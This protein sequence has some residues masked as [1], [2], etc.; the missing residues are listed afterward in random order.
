MAT[1]YDS[2]NQNYRS[3]LVYSRCIQSGYAVEVV[4]QAAASESRRLEEAAMFLRRTIIAAEREAY[5]MSWPPPPGNELK[6]WN[7]P[8]TQVLQFLSTLLSG[9][10][11]RRGLSIGRDI[12]YAV[13][14]GRWMTP[15]HIMLGMSVWH[16]T[17]RLDII[18]ILN[19]FGHCSRLL[20]ILTAI[21]M[22]VTDHDSPIPPGIKAQ[23]NE[24][25]H[26]CWDNFDLNEETHL[27]RVQHTQPMVL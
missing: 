9:N 11:T 10:Q 5:D 16:L 15:K 13:T 1:G 21:H 2:G 24:V 20:E 23:C 22:S 12:V 25:L 3:E 4:F 6:E 14:R 19:R 17:G 7:L 27:E 26:F 8:P 18:T